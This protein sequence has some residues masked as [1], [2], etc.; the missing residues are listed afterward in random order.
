M[1]AAV[2]PRRRGHAETFSEVSPA[3]TKRIARKIDRLVRH[4]LPI[5]HLAFSLGKLARNGAHIHQRR[6]VT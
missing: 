6:E 4:H 1:I 3:V 2:E 5:D